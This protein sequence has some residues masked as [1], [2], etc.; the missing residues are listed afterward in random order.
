MHVSF[1]S[2]TVH[3]LPKLSSV[4]PISRKSAWKRFGFKIL[5]LERNADDFGH[6]SCAWVVWE[7]PQILEKNKAEILRNSLPKFA[8]KFAGNFPE[9]RRTKLKSSPQIHSAAPRDQ[10]LHTVRL[11]IMTFLNTKTINSCKCNCE[12]FLKSSEGNYSLHSS[13]AQ[14][15]QETVTV[16]KSD[17]RSPENGTCTPLL[18]TTRSTPT[19]GIPISQTSNPD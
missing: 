15:K 17:S 6:E 2:T 13:L 4:S 19:L 10:L 7:G 5:K 3:P 18:T 11:E 16:V 8:E 1:S 14:R 9:I 12:N